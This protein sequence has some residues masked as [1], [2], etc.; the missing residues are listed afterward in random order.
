[1]CAHTLLLLL[2]QNGWSRLCAVVKN[3]DCLSQIL[4][5]TYF[6]MVF[7]SSVPNSS[8]TAQKDNAL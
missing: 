2:F 1:M 8:Y 3:E 5:N 4:L 6:L 7:L